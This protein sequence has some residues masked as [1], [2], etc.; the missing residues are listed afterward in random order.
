MGQAFSAAWSTDPL[1][2]RSI[3]RIVPLLPF[4]VVNYLSGIARIST[5]TFIWTT[6][7]GMLP[8]T[9]VCTFAGRQLSVITTPDE[10]FSVKVVMSLILLALL[11]LLPPA[12]YHI[13]N[14]RNSL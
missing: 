13:K 5:W 3:F 7:L 1:R 10:I 9:L 8:G 12:A 11:I 4:F 2:A 14:L 6:F